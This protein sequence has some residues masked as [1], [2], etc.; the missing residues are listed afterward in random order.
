MYRSESSD[1]SDNGIV[2]SVSRNG[3]GTQSA[4]SPSLNESELQQLQVWNAT[5]QNFPQDVFVPQLVALQAATTPDAT[6]VVKENQR[7]SYR[8]LN[9]R[10]NQLAHYLRACGVQPDTLVGLCLDRSLDM[11]VGLLAILKAG[12]A[13][14]PLDPSYPSERLIFML[15][16]ADIS[17]LVTRQTIAEH[18][19]AY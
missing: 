8:E 4:A 17:V 19:S 3:K 10:A 9:E 18:L 12:G 6:A 16:D 11:V 14:V 7:L 13:Y 1:R 15:Q 5:T 2:S